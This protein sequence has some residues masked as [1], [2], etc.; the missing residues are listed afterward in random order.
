MEFIEQKI[1]NAVKNLLTGKVNEYLQQL[2]FQI[3]II[4]FGIFRGINVI[5]PIIALSSCEQTEK[6]RIIKQDSYS[7]TVTFPVFDTVE[8]ELF[9]YAYADAVNKALADDVTLG[10][11]ADRALITGKKY[12][13]PKKPD[14]SL[15]WELNISMRITI[16]A[17]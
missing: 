9:C 15:D 16:E 5:A 2:D 1:I 14:C 10:G 4:E 11:V 6:E 7:L 12:V 13:P 17:V 8:S 3:P